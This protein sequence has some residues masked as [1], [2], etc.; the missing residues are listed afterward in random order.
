[1]LGFYLWQ[2]RIIYPVPQPSSV[3]CCDPP[4]FKLQGS[5]LIVLTLGCVSGR[6]QG[7]WVHPDRRGVGAKA[8]GFH[9]R[10]T[11]ELAGGSSWG[12]EEG[13]LMVTSG[14]EAGTAIV[15]LLRGPIKAALDWQSL[16]EAKC[17]HFSL[18]WTP[19]T[20]IL[21]CHGQ[22]CVS[23]AF[24]ASHCGSSLRAI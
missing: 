7:L 9:P 14:L 15:V 8:A 3:K 22:A 11:G 1:M 16:S 12:H 20:V 21:G 13:C 24:S 5:R 4:K 10:R 2:S 17:F 23:R 18:G 6:V 19:G